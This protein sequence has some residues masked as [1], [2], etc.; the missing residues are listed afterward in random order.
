MWVIFLPA[1]AQCIESQVRSYLHCS[2]SICSSP[3]ER[4]SHSRKWDQP[5]FQCLPLRPWK[6]GGHWTHSCHL[7]QVPSGFWDS[8]KNNYHRVPL[9]NPMV[10]SHLGTWMAL[11]T[12]SYLTGPLVR[13]PTHIDISARLCIIIIVCT[14]RCTPDLEACQQSRHSCRSGRPAGQQ[15]FAE[16]QAR[17]R[18]SA[19]HCTAPEKLS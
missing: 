5:P 10:G 7:S 4:N 3:P 19:C 6:V 8:G 16:R 15:R 17:R 1:C 12:P 2:R 18:W 9:G 14:F 11:T 13:W